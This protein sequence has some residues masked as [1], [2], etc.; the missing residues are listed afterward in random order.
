MTRSVNFQIFLSTLLI[1]SW[2]ISWILLKYALVSTD[3]FIFRSA[4]C[5]FCAIAL[6]PVALYLKRNLIEPKFLVMNTIIS[7]PNIALWHILSALGLLKSMTGNAVVIAYTMPIWAMVFGSI[8]YRERLSAKKII[9]CFLGCSSVAT[10]YISQGAGEPLLPI[11]LLVGAAMSWGLG[12][13][14]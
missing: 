3:P 8:F 11:A 13:A 4:V 5:L 12:T 6:F 14:M 10:V 1:F 7:V 9:A 2:S